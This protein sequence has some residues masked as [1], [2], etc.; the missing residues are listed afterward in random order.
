VIRR[1][2]REIFLRFFFFGLRRAAGFF[3]A[4]LVVLGPES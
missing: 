3:L 4:D 1:I 2:R